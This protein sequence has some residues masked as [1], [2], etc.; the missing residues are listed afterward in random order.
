MRLH[1]N[2][3]N[4]G[5]DAADDDDDDDDSDSDIVIM[6]FLNAYYILEWNSWLITL[7]ITSN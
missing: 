6:V 4:D 3:S 7:E 2:D 5:S 1:D